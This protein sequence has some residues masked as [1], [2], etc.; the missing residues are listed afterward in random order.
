V[1]E[2]DTNDLRRTKSDTSDTSNTN[3]LR[4]R[5]KKKKEKD[6]YSICIF[7]GKELIAE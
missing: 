7:E 2:C 3:D 4:R 1:C 6:L 5:F